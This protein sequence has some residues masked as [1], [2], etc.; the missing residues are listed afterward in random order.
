MS[1]GPHGLSALLL[2]YGSVAIPMA[3]TLFRRTADSGKALA[4]AAVAIPVT[5]GAG[6]AT[7]IA[8]PL[9]YGLGIERGSFLDLA[10]GIGIYAG[11][12]YAAGRALARPALATSVHQRG[13]I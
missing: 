12:G 3:V 5:V 1:S 2:S 10:A 11:V 6:I 4:S 7:V 8:S 13:T 9:I